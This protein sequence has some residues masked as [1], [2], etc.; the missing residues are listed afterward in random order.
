MQHDHEREVPEA[1]LD[2]TALPA[3]R[4]VAGRDDELGDPLEADQRH[5]DGERDEP[6]HDAALSSTSSEQK[7]GAHRHQDA[8]AAGGR[9][10]LAQGVL[11]DVEHR[12]RGEVAHPGQRL[13][14]QSDRLTRHLER[15]LERLDHLGTTG[16][17]HPPADVGA[18]E[19]VVGEEGVDVA[20]HEAA[21]EGRHL[22]VEHDAQAVA[23]DVEAHRALAVGV[24]PAA[25]VEDLD[26]SGPTGPAG[27]PDRD[28]RRG[29]VTEQAARHEVGHRRVVALHGQRAQLHGDQHRGVVGVAQEVVVHAGD[30]GGTG[31][32]P[33]PDERHPAHVLPQADLRGDARVE[34]GHGEPGDRRGDHEVDVGRGQV[35]GLERVDECARA[36]LDGVLDE[37]V[38]G[39]PEVAEP[40]VL[41][42]AGRTVWRRSTPAFAWK[43][44]SSDRSR[45]RS[46]MNCAKA[47]VISACGWEWGGSAPRTERILMSATSG[48]GGRRQV[49]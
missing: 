15:V 33:E 34:G 18:G 24:E 2:A 8:M 19:P 40:G 23:G 35:G 46:E 47:S 14:G 49:G 28:D 31:H 12:Y 48:C 25:R 41:G 13:P 6:G 39:V 7:P 5:Q 9:R 4:G 21:H 17:A 1:V 37:E 20:A 45:L 22:R 44:R 11:Q 38:V 29:A 27:S 36:E 16:V 10:A 30:A 26:R 43:R 42:R 3:P 32:A